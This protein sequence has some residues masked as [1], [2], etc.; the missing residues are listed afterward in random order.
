MTRSG[1]AGV[2]AVALAGLSG[3]D[4]QKPK[5]QTYEVKAPDPVAEAKAILQNYA[6]GQP[7][8]SEAESFPDLVKRVKAVDAAKGDIL[9]QGFKDI[10][11]KK[12]NPGPTAKE[13]LKKL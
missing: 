4:S 12:N 10:L 13:L 11:A 6:N 1:F 2:L 5:V 8:T 9:E 7:V 3:C